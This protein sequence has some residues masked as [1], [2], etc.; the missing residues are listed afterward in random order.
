MRKNA[1]LF[2]LRYHSRQA[3]FRVALVVFFLLGI[4]MSF[5]RFGDAH[6]NAPYVLGM[7]TGLLS[8]TTVFAAT[9]F[10]ANVCLRDVRYR[11]EPLLFSTSLRRSDYFLSRLSG[12]WLAV[13]A[14]LTVSLA[15][16]ATGCLIQEHEVQGP[17]VAG[18]FLHPLVVF[19]VPNVLVI[20]SLLFAVALF[21]RSERSVY[22]TGVLLYI[23]YLTG[24]ILG[25]SPLI[26]GS[27]LKDGPQN[28]WPLLGDPFG[29][30]SFFGDTRLWT[31][32]RKNSELYGL[33]GA[34]GWNRAV[35]TG[36]SAVVLFVT[37]R[38]FPFRLPISSP[39]KKKMQEAAAPA[40]YR[41]IP[42]QATGIS[43]YCWVFWAR[44]E[45][46][47]RLLFRQIPFWVMLLLWVFLYAVELQDAWYG[48]PYGM[49]LLPTTGLLVEEVRA[50]RLALPVLLFFSSEMVWSDRQVRFSDI[51]TATPVAGSLLW[52]SKMTVLALLILVLIGATAITGVAS[53]LAAGYTDLQPCTYLS[54]ACYG[55]LPLLYVTVLLLF[56]QA[57]T[58]NRYLGL[59]LGLL[60]MAL[61]LFSRRI[62]LE[63]PLLRY[64]TPPEL[65]Y[66]EMSGWGHYADAFDGYML[67]WGAAAASI[68]ILTAAWWGKRRPVFSRSLKFLLILALCTWAGTGVALYQ[69]LAPTYQSQQSL[70][71]QGI[72]YE[73]RYKRLGLAAQPVIQA[74]QLAVDLFPSERKYRVR[75][76]YRLR[77]ESDK[78]LS[79]IWVGTD[80]GTMTTEIT[81]SERFS[82]RTEGNQHFLRLSRPLLPGRELT[83]RFSMEADRSGYVPFDA[84]HSV[85]PNGSYI[86][87]EKFLPWLGY[88][89][90]LET[91]DRQARRKAG[92]PE[93]SVPIP[94]DSLYH[95]VHQD[96]TVTT[97][98]GQ[99]V[100]AIGTL[101]ST[102]NSAGRPVF[103]YRLDGPFR[104]ALSSARYVVRED[105]AGTT[106]I[107][108]FYHPGHETNVPMLVKAAKDALTYAD[109][110]FHP[111]PFPELTI[112]E[113][114]RYP[115]AATAYP[116]TVFSAENIN[117]LGNF[118]RNAFPHAYAI[119]A[120]EISHQW[121]PHQMAPVGGPGDGLLT[122]SLAKYA[123]AVIT[124]RFTGREQLSTYLKR[125]NNF[126]FGMR[127]DDEKPLTRSSDQLYVEYQKGGLVLYGLRERLGED[128][129]N[130]ALKKLVHRYRYPGR[131]VRPA[132]LLRELTVG[133]S[134][135][136]KR[137]IR[138][139]LQQK[140]TYDLSIRV[141]KTERR[142]D[143]SYRLLL[144]IS[145]RK[146]EN[147][148]KLPVD[149]DMEV[150]V[151]GDS[152]RL[153]SRKYRITEDR[154]RLSLV[155][156]QRPDQVM[157]DPMGYILDPDQRDNSAKVK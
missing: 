137:L 83:L 124:E 155:V 35:W 2:E 76:T 140:T 64:A 26:A 32:S 84:E 73:K 4:G 1:W 29:L 154:T 22:V 143:G 58:P 17:Y 127:E 138:E 28:I 44:L 148:R 55:G 9:I 20:V 117:F 82:D 150:A 49:R 75:G 23:L 100:V 78:P 113:I 50:F 85:V 105:Q 110:A 120:H 157:V 153:F 16:V 7:L 147:G 144:E 88:N 101:I 31:V 131:R 80:P 59:V 96:I 103:R 71:N 145:A 108:I 34:F 134:E 74:T 30:S 13:F 106:R 27:P 6:K 52:A 94:A 65:Y 14:I 47:I 146:E 142:P 40:V 139:L 18:W 156:R 91:R 3:S 132:D 38:R 125:D 122:E 87:L 128:R 24:S 8:L 39:E 95:P 62:G 19:G 119:L 129:V 70:I 104:C 56:V 81:L 107:R 12:L 109:T 79:Q 45:L 54:L 51:L 53:Q 98:P 149:E 130:R 92:L 99:T 10:T 67:Y 21:S 66:S 15:G 89:P 72:S 43:W 93:E 86:E 36:F 135:R 121:W 69:R 115:G 42:V 41:L 97:D 63:H 61:V 118:S 90:R 11:M 116:G 37:Y 60:V 5:G 102:G 25:G 48:G 114:P 46:E 126:Y 136:E 141:L 77:N 57:I 152:G 112:A 151:S 123:E 68:G 33:S 133:A 111:Y